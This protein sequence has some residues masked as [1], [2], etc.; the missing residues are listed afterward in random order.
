MLLGTLFPCIFSNDVLLF[1]FPVV[2]PGVG[3]LDRIVILDLVFWET[4]ILFSTMA[5]PVYIVPTVNNSAF[6]PT[7]LPFVICIYF[8][9]SHSDRCRWSR[10]GF[11]LHFYKNYQYWAC[12]HVPVGHLCVFFGKKSSLS[13]S[14]F[15]KK[16]LNCMC[17]LY[18]LNINP[19][20]SSIFSNSIVCLSFRQWFPLLCKSF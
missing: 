3:L 6:S 18:S 9:D 4:S 14:W 13:I 5:A 1:L 16:I 8:D 10:Y 2:H 15:S 12:F 19:C 20:W 17:H 11:D 7:S